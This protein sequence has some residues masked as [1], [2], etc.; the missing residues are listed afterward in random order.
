MYLDVM[1]KMVSECDNPKPS[2]KD[3]LMCI[4]DIMS[5][6]G[7]DSHFVDTITP[8]VYESLALSPKYLEKQNGHPNETWIRFNTRWAI[9]AG[10]NSGLLKYIKRTGNQAKEDRLISGSS[11]L[12]QR[13]KMT[14]MGEKAGKG[15]FNWDLLDDRGNYIDTFGG[16]QNINKYFKESFL[17]CP[18]INRIISVMER[19]KSII[20]QGPPGT[21]KTFLADKLA[22][23]LTGDNPDKV[24]KIQFHQSYS[25]D[26]F[27]RG[28][29]PDGG[30]WKLCDGVFVELCNRALADQGN[31]YVMVIDE[32]NRGDL[33]QIFGEALTFLEPDKRNR[34][35]RLVYGSDDDGKIF[36]IP[37]NVFLI[38]TMNT[39]D[40]GL[41]HVDYATRRRFAFADI[42]SAVNDN[43]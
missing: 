41:T 37:S 14:A 19:K 2:R 24:V 17:T 8:L 29:R 12:C 36:T 21:G 11:H 33:N 15:L 20:L 7:S 30:S 9:T 38:G 1:A 16:K 25:Y 31:R 22:S 10:K 4:V 39:A 26:D 18:D 3:I 28:Y 13:F 43:E 40:K 5:K 35:V 42:P 34:P 32:I 6:N 23:F 27:I